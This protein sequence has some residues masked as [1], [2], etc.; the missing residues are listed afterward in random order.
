[1][2]RGLNSVG[3]DDDQ[4]IAAVLTGVRR[5]ALLGASDHPQR[6][7]FAVLRFLLER[8]YQVFPVNPAL[9][10][11]RLVGQPVYPEL[12]SLP[13]PID[14]VDVFRRPEHLPAIV[15]DC[16]SIGATVLWTQL[17]VVH[18]GALSRAR[19]AGLVVIADRCPA[20]EWPRLVASGLLGDRQK[21]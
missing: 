18:E 10:G 5:V 4:T 16:L 12:T 9:A 14:M 7:S 6:P 13:E 3:A 21:A 19:A 20:I 1:M 8:G 11:T 15:D 2:G 17:G